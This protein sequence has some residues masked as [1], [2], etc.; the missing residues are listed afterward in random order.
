VKRLPENRRE[1]ATKSQPEVVQRDP[2]HRLI[3][4]ARM[5]SAKA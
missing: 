1:P 5:R 4:S 2:G 3:A